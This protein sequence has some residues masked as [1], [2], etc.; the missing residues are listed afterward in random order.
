MLDEA[1]SPGT[2]HPPSCSLLPTVARRLLLGR[3]IHLQ[4]GSIGPG[5]PGSRLEEEKALAT[6]YTAVELWQALRRHAPSSYL[7]EPL[8]F[9]DITTGAFSITES[10][11][12]LASPSSARQHSPMIVPL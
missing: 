5:T 6:L 11:T 9:H 12:V 10:C 8:A 2:P 7:D 1:S 4:S 3:V